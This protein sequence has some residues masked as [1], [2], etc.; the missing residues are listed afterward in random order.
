MSTLLDRSQTLEA[1]PANQEEAG[2]LAKLLNA[3]P[4]QP[5]AAVHKALLEFLCAM[6]QGQHFVI[7]ALD[8]ELTPARAAKILGMSRTYFM[9]IVQSGAI[10]SHHVGKHHRVLLKD[11]LKFQETNRQ[12]AK[13]LAELTAQAQDLDMGY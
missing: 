2:R 4:V 11:V 5:N 10:P 1:S 13:M 7:L 12:K 3:A 9:R 8:R 6:Q